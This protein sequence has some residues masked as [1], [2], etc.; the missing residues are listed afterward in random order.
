MSTITCGGNLETIG[1]LATCN[2]SYLLTCQPQPETGTGIGFNVNFVFGTKLLTEVVKQDFVKV[3]ATQ[4]AVPCMGK[5]LQLAFL[6]GN[7]GDLHSTVS[8][9]QAF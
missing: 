7:N 5:H 4:I 6:E 1:C 2:C 9:R 3:S 8:Q